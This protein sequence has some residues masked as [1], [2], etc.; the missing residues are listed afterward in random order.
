MRWHYKVVTATLCIN[1]ILLPVNNYLNFTLQSLHY[2]YFNIIFF[3]G[4]KLKI[5]SYEEFSHEIQEKKSGIIRKIRKCLTDSLILTFDHVT[6]ISLG[7]IYSLGVSNIPNL[8]PIKK[9]K[10]LSRQHFF[11]RTALWHWLLTSCNNVALPYFTFG[12]LPSPRN[13]K[14]LKIGDSYVIAANFWPEHQ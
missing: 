4:K 12:Y 7:N 3:K 8:V 1:K 13:I 14:I 2:Y 6:W 5:R 10:I 11:Q 9:F